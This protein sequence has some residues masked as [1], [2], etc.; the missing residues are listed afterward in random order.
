M[1]VTKT[2]IKKEKEAIWC[3]IREF[4]EFALVKRFRSRLIF[5]KFKKDMLLSLNHPS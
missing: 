2:I 3:F 4:H 1:I 5:Y